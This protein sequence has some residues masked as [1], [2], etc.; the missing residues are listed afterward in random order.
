MTPSSI[1]SPSSSLAFEIGG[2]STEKSPQ[3]KQTPAKE[4]R[5]DWGN[6]K[7]LHLKTPLNPKLQAAINGTN[8]LEE[9]AAP[10]NRMLERTSP[11]QF[12]SKGKK[13]MTTDK[14]E[15]KMEWIKRRRPA[16]CAT[17]SIAKKY[18]DVADMK[19]EIGAVQLSILK[20]AE[21]F[22]I[23]A[24]KEWEIDV[25][26]RREREEEIHCYTVQAQKIDIAIKQAQ[27]DLLQKT[28]NNYLS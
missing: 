2:T 4:A 20:R 8:V 28:N 23:Q 15:N 16:L 9:E 7:A 14:C 27:P 18:E 13:R 24:K 12:P 5:V 1:R 26:R 11:I 25:K 6:R 3:P 21:Q 19:T 10:R 22:Q 17:T